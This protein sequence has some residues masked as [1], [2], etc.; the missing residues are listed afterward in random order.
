M[1]ENKLKIGDRVLINDPELVD[2][3]CLIV[4]LQ[5]FRNKSTP[6][7][8]CWFETPFRLR[9]EILYETFQHPDDLIKI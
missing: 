3:P 8:Q 9:G 1:S 6:Y 5:T 7:F 4:D 2:R